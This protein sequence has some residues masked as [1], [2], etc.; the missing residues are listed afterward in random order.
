MKKFDFN[1]ISNFDEHILQSIPNYDILYNSILRMSEFFV[2]PNKAIYDVGCSTG[3]LIIEL[4][5]QYPDNKIVGLDNSANLL[6][7]LK[8]P[9]FVT[10]DL[11]NSYEF[12]NA[13]II[14]SIFTLQFL[15][16]E[17]RQD[18]INNIYEGLCQ[19]GA[20]IIAE[21]TF[22]K[23]PI[24]QDVFTFSY[25]DYKK[26]SFTDAEILSKEK[27]LR[28]ILKPNPVHENLKMLN[29]AGFKTI[30]MFY[31]FFHF[32]AYLCIK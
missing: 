19:G 14:Y 26:V 10:T 2:L 28:K 15:R 4:Q 23:Y 12:H 32:E 7:K 13:C 11:N 8:K 29:K 30:Q 31:K 6:P 21:K 18:L 27:D 17:K 1:T 25:Y 20:F 16:K 22:A 24:T 3:K 9:I 5:K